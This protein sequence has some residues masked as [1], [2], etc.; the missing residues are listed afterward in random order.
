MDRRRRWAVGLAV[1]VIAG[2]FLWLRRSPRG[3]PAEPE[4][5]RVA[6]A[7]HESD[8]LE[9]PPGD[10]LLRDY[11]RLGGTVEVDLQRLG[12]VLANFR[13]THKALD[14]R[15]LATNAEMAA[16]LRG[17]TPGTRPMVSADA[18]I[19]DA[20]GRL[21]DRW[22][23]PLVVHVLG[24]DKIELR[25]AGPDRRAWNADDFVRLA[26]GRVVRGA[27]VSQ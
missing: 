26:N 7:A 6:H 1:V 24:A 3:S 22:G 17:E 19:F 16:A 27:E 11:G 14:V 10:A 4:P 18:T 5:P 25:S 9:P 13:L 15:F 8:A 2:G 20:D 12:Q 21:I 23:T